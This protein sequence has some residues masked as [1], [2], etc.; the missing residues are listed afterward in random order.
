MN[1]VTSYLKNIG[2]SVAYATVD[3]AT[4]KM[5]PEVKDFVDTNDEIFKSVYATVSHSKKSI[6][7]GKK[8]ASDSQIYKDINKGFKNALDDI[9]TGNFYNKTR[10]ETENEAFAESMFGGVFDDDDFNFDFDT[11]DGSLD[12]FQDKPSTKSSVTQGDM[13]VAN[14]INKTSNLAAQLISS[15]V[16]KTSNIISKTQLHTTNMIMAQNVEL[17]AGLRTSIAGMH[18]S[19]NSILKFAQEDIKT[20]INNESKY[21]ETT[22]SLMQEN[23]AILKEMLEMQRNL[24]KTQDKEKSNDK[25]GD[26]FSGGTLDIKEYLKAVTSNIKNLDKTGTTSMLT[27]DIG[28]STMIGQMMSNPLGFIMT[29]LVEKFIPLNLGKT[30]GNFSKTLGNLFPAMITK[31]NSWKNNK[32]GIFGI[33]G[34]IFGIDID[35]KSK[36]DTSKYKKEAVPFDGITR[37]AI[38]DVIP[39]HLSKI[40]SL[41]AGGKSQRVY[42]YHTGKW[43][44]SKDIEKKQKEDYDYMLKDS[45][46]ELSGELRDFVTELK[47]QKA[48]DKKSEASLNEDI[49][50]MMKKTFEDG[51]HF[52]PEEIKKNI[53]SYKFDNEDIMQVMMDMFSTLPTNKIA[54][55]SKNTLYNKKRW[56]DNRRNAEI[57]G[58][59]VQRKLYDNSY[60]EEDGFYS[61]DSKKKNKGSVNKKNK[62]KYNSKTNRDKALDE[63]VRSTREKSDKRDSNDF[64]NFGKM[65]KSKN[66]YQKA[67]EDIPGNSFIEKFQNANDMQ[68]KFALI[69]GSLSD[70]AKKPA[71]LL[72]GLVAKADQSIYNLLFKADTN[73]YDS[74]GKKIKGLFNAMLDNMKNKWE[75]LTTS[76]ME[77]L[78]DPLAKKYG[79]DDKLD[80]LKKRAKEGVF[81][82][83]Q[84]DEDG[85]VIKNEYGFAKRSQGLLT[86][87]MYAMQ[88]D[89]RGMVGYT[90]DSISEVLSSLIN[91]PTVANF[92][93]SLNDKKHKLT[94]KQ[95]IAKLQDI[96]NNLPESEKKKL[97]EDQ[98]NLLKNLGI[99]GL[100]KGGK[101]TKAGLIA[102]SEGE[103]VTVKNKNSKNIKQNQIGESNRTLNAIYDALLNP[104]A[105]MSEHEAQFGIPGFAKGGKAENDGFS[106][107]DLDKLLKSIQDSD[108][109]YKNN[110]EK[111][112]TN[113]N[114]KG[115]VSG[116]F[117]YIKNLFG[118][119]KDPEKEKGKI[120]SI[121]SN[122]L[123]DIGGKGPEI[124]SKAII[125]GGL[126]LLSGVAAGPLLG[127]GIGAAIGLSKNSKTINK[128]LFG[129]ET[130]DKDGNIIEKPGFISKKTQEA[131]KKYL[132]DMGKYG[133]TGAVASLMLPFGPLAGAVIGAGVGLAKNSETMNSMLF[134]DEEGL[135]NKQRRDKIKDYFPKA[136]AGAVA[137]LFLGPFGVM[138][139][140]ALGAGVGMLTNTEE[141][142]NLIFGEPGPNGSRFGGLKGALDEHFINPLKEFGSNFKEDF[143]GFIRESMIDPLNRAIT[144]I[145]SEIAFQTKRV[146]FGIP[147]MFAKLGKEYIAQPFMSKV[148]DYFISPLGQLTQKLFGGAFNKVKGVVSFPFR[149]IGGI[150][151]HFRKKQIRQGRDEVG[152]AKDRIQFAESKKMGDYQYRGFD[153]ALAENS[154]NEDYLK[155]VTARTGML[156]HGA[157]YFEKQVQATGKQLSKVLDDYIKLGWMSKNKK[158]YKRIKNYI[159]NNDVESA[160]KELNNIQQSRTDGGKMSD[161]NAD[162]AIRRFTEANKSYQATKKARE[163]FG[164]VNKEDNE[165][166]M[167]EQFGKNWR[168]LDSKRLFKYSSKE[169][170][171]ATGNKEITKQELLKDP[172]KLVTEGDNM[173]NR[174]LKEIKV[175]IES[176]AKG[177]FSYSKDSDNYD[178]AA[179]SGKKISKAERQ[180]QRINIQ[181]TLISKGLDYGKDN[182]DIISL[183]YSNAEIYQLVL[184][185]IDKG[186]SYDTQTIKRLCDLN[187]SRKDIQLLKKYPY[188]AGLPT[189]LLKKYLNKYRNDYG[190]IIRNSGIRNKNLDQ[191]N[192]AMEKGI[193]IKTE[194]RAKMLTSGGFD[195]S[196]DHDLR[197]E[198]YDKLDS[199]GL[200]N[201]KINF[202]GKDIKLT[203]KMIID[204]KKGLSYEDM[205]SIIEN[206]GGTADIKNDKTSIKSSI[207]NFSDKHLGFAKKTAGKAA[208]VAG[209]GGLAAL[210]APITLPLAALGLG[211][212]AI[213]KTAGF[214]GS[215]ISDIKNLGI[216]GF[217]NDK[218]N[219]SKV[220]SDINDTDLSDIAKDTNSSMTND[221]NGIISGAKDKVKAFFTE[222]GV[223]NYIRNKRGDWTLSKDSTTKETLEKNNEEENNQSKILSSINTMK[224]GI[225]GI[226]TRHKK[227]DEEEEKEP[228]YKKLFKTKIGKA[229]TF[230]GILVAGHKLVEWWNSPNSDGNPIKQ[231]LSSAVDKVKEF[232]PTALESAVSNIGGALEWAIGDL[233]PLAMSS[234]FKS[235]PKI[236]GGLFNGVIKGLGSIFNI[237]FHSKDEVDLSKDENTYIIPKN[238]DNNE[239][240]SLFESG[241]KPGSE[242]YK[243]FLRLRKSGLGSSNINIESEESSSSTSTSSNDSSNIPDKN[244]PYNKNSSTTTSSN[245]SSKDMVTEN[246]NKGVQNANNN[247]IIAKRYGQN[248]DIT[249]DIYIKK[250]N[251]YK[252]ISVDDFNNNIYSEVYFKTKDGR[253]LKA[254]YDE[255]NDAYRIN[256]QEGFDET[257][258]TTYGDFL[259]KKTTKSFIFGSTMFSNVDSVV[260]KT[261][262]KLIK[263][264]LG[265]IPGTKTIGKALGGG[266]NFMGNLSSFGA[267][268]AASLGKNVTSD[269]VKKGPKTALNTLKSNASSMINK[270]SKNSAKNA[271]TKAA[272]DT[273]EKATSKVTKNAAEN[274]AEKAAS[275]ITDKVTKEGAEELTSKS[276]T[277][278]I[279][280]ITSGTFSMDDFLTVLSQLINYVSTRVSSITKYFKNPKLLKDLGVK[281]ISS[282]KDDFLKIG[283]KGIMKKATSKLTAWLAS[284]GIALAADA[285]YSFIK[286]MNQADGIIGIRNTDWGQKAI[287]G[288]SHVIAET[289][290]FGLLNHCDVAQ[291]LLELFGYDMKEIDKKRGE[292]EKERQ[293]YCIEEET[294][295]SLEEFLNKDTVFTKYIDPFGNGVN[296]LVGGV[297]DGALSIGGGVFDAGKNTLGGILSGGSQIL[298]GDILGGLGTMGSGVVDGAKSLGKGVIDGGKKLVGGVVDGAKSFG[299]GIYNAGSDFVNWITGNN[300]K[301]DKKAA[302]NKEVEKESK[303]KMNFG[304][305]GAAAKAIKSTL[306]NSSDILKNSNNITET[307]AAA[308]TSNIAEQQ[309]NEFDAMSSNIQS[310]FTITDMQLGKAYGFTDSKGNYIS[311][312]KGI[313]S[314]KQNSKNKG[315][316]T[317]ADVL[318]AI[319]GNMGNLL[320]TVNTTGTEQVTKSSG[321]FGGIASGIKGGLSIMGNLFGGK[322]SGKDD[323]VSQIDPKY[324]NQKFNRSGD[325]N[326]Q[327]LGDSGCA[328]ATAANVLNLYAGKGRD[329]MISA[330]EAALRYKETDGGVTPEYF[331][332][333][334]GKKGIGTYS[335]MNKNEML[336]GISSGKPTILLGSDPTNRSNT[337]YGSSSS[338]Y[339]LATGM[340]GKGNVIVQDPES[341]RPN[342]LYPVKDVVNQSHLGMITGRGSGLIS[343][344]KSRLK[345][346]LGILGYGKGIEET[347][348]HQDLGKWSEITAEELNAAIDKATG[349]KQRGFTG[350]G[351]YFVKAAKASGLDP[352]YILAHSAEETG[353]GDSNYA[354]AG[355]F[356][357][358]GAFDSN[359]DNALKYGNDDME[360]G[361]INGAKWIRK[362]YYDAGQTTLYKMRH[363]GGKHEYATNDTWHTNIARIMSK[364]P[365]NTN[366]VYHE[367]DDSIAATSSGSKA[368]TLFGMLESLPEAYFGSELM[369]LFG[370]NTS[371]STTGAAPASSPNVEKAISQMEAWANDPNVGYDQTYRWGEKGD[372]DCSGAVISAYENAGIPVKTNGASYTGNMLSAFKKSGFSDI[373]SQINLGTGDGL[374]RGDVLLTPSKHTAMY[375]GDGQEVEASINEKGTATGGQPGDQT[376]KEFLIQK[377]RNHPW[378]N[379]L[380]YTGS[381]TGSNKRKTNKFLNNVYSGMGTNNV[382]SSANNIRKIS[383]PNIHQTTKNNSYLPSLEYDNMNNS[384]LSSNNNTYSNSSNSNTDR[385]LS[386][387]IEILQIIANNS[388]KL[389]EIVS[390]LSKS[391][392]LNL[393][394]NDISKLSSNN[395][396]IKNKIANALKSQGSAN[397]MGSSIM[398]A[399]TESLASAMYSIARA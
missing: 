235:L 177:I 321:I 322:G 270:T 228:W 132:P 210:T 96:F 157:E 148:T 140:A 178:E 395:S 358:I 160:I 36:I 6:N 281:F 131:F 296:N 385:L 236:L 93:S 87:T 377:Y 237:V 127:A 44:S 74:E 111:I 280:K 164:V 288:L 174:T 306:P 75:E 147:K 240:L 318:N 78:I 120:N 81:G 51:G 47:E 67:M 48:L 42:D 324:R 34:D 226:F 297:F 383:L 242:L 208:A 366:A 62:Y 361:L 289:L 57:L 373:T 79:L 299:K 133:V 129:E 323:F 220:N 301:D 347:I 108:E 346:K 263:N 99:T 61:S 158:A 315:Q 266:L 195:Q 76:L 249:D 295:I 252:K 273:I 101:V 88:K 54:S 15:T 199:M 10:E 334:L 3:V 260:L 328:P 84:K 39:E 349:G 167:E 53:K 128:F 300:K 256:K 66:H 378:N 4:T 21:F 362:N 28:G 16:A 179:E 77:K 381:G 189:K 163:D 9:K 214:V 246:I 144:P 45:F 217:I 173:I 399:S 247:N 234:L 291:F 316:Y 219:K 176:S 106:F 351:E 298:S 43:I 73:E 137:G 119:N 238:K 374:Q 152:T 49:I 125:G 172:T 104:N 124:A 12:D 330:S 243:N 26:V 201:K 326:S 369:S 185:N 151:D 135:F 332:N 389:S 19:I 241:S 285:A 32:G 205:N 264:T 141:F 230:G 92:R 35:T 292:A 293:A 162:E 390:L 275:K 365:G 283:I 197:L 278:M 23:N 382:T 353:W 188:I 143:F 130:T 138:G 317:F 169:L 320:N 105:D 312:S 90:K 372:Y 213:G 233:L 313:E 337:P 115:P 14:S 262:G 156:A 386:I 139:N 314:F 59:S 100:A 29:S 17:M 166:W 251:E 52:S 65:I 387:I 336:S 215:N 56:A 231:F 211:G 384:V 145:A 305:L 224:D 30:I 41:L 183:L 304:A 370:G 259:A 68:T 388:E 159:K 203:T 216:K 170:S 46:S 341:R 364:M 184:D 150:G 308:G 22:T 11:D 171:N 102:V 303:G 254:D 20:Q 290:C 363:N 356:F 379:V 18:Q 319:N 136:A 175:L 229:L 250:N 196:Y 5:I 311:L 392:D 55:V 98:L 331:Q 182:N 272:S 221:A 396:Q 204:S 110:K 116:I 309:A 397:G 327:T 118:L 267:N 207:N 146:V 348:I 97:S 282:F 89:Y 223:M 83:V 1:K 114:T 121:I 398:D 271:A 27:T 72:T 261:G 310:A 95:R 253:M 63:A 117:D 194:S 142:K 40:E 180:K 2:K 70:I 94:R 209:L 329:E 82:R 302:K 200:I 193:N 123:D 112:N 342:S 91:D 355:N 269:L 394:D 222:N 245:K 360:S 255:L 38:V 350:K 50:K 286:G 103:E 37:K 155:E 122:V 371:T 294:N 359:P 71:A 8:L 248:I 60:D 367:P 257:D 186:I 31:L 7:Y 343:G 368:S 149:T 307:T 227:K 86:P 206:N 279:S 244:I 339:V 64:E 276:A 376:G 287:A 338:H 24:Y 345:A 333:Y 153:E 165:K 284:V 380:R 109:K 277:T 258:V 212:L 13:V 134:G 375:S 352:R 190:T 218:K 265:Q 393:T 69:M 161:E 80:N 168:K 344:I 202:N 391:L 340:D 107:E 198:Y 232:I 325:T 239:N 126:G 33:L 192:T 187:L 225:L 335:T 154:N 357:G 181:T 354:K 85:K 191:L 274:A 268:S 58:D 25:F 113:K